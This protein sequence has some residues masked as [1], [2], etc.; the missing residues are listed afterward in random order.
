MQQARIIPL[1]QFVGG[2]VR[3]D[4]QWPSTGDGDPPKDVEDFAAQS[5][6]LEFDR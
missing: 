3:G 1:F 4:G 2:D 5:V 6:H